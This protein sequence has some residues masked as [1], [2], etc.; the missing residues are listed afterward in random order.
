MDLDTFVENAKLICKT[1][2]IAVSAACLNAGLSVSW[3]SDIENKGTRPRIDTVIAFAHYLG[4]TVSELIGETQPQASDNLVLHDS[5]VAVHPT[6]M[7]R[8]KVAEVEMVMA[9]RKASRKEQRIIDDML[10][11]YKEKSTSVG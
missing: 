5:A 4:V 9:Y 7:K 10:A 11:E 6:D 3:L 8:L 1:K 2:G